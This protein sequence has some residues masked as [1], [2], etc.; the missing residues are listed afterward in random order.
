MCLMS[1]QN[2]VEHSHISPEISK[3]LQPL[4]PSFPV[5][6]SID[7][8]TILENDETLFI[9][10]LSTLLI[11]SPLG[12]EDLTVTYCFIQLLK[13]AYFQLDSLGALDKVLADCIISPYMHWRFHFATPAYSRQF[14]DFAKFMKLGMPRMHERRLIVEHFERSS[15]E[16]EECDRAMISDATSAMGG[17]LWTGPA[18]EIVLITCHELLRS[19]AK[20]EPLTEDAADRESKHR[21]RRTRSKEEKDFSKNK[22]RKATPAVRCS[23]DEQAGII[24]TRNVARSS[25]CANNDRRRAQVSRSKFEWHET[26]ATNMFG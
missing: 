1:C 23:N 7:F 18:E 25:L 14:A 21:M 20:H 12:L 4:L 11:S 6:R 5:L 24:G 8:W 22:R 26:L 17:G 16:D 15:M 2:E 3:P 13:D 10:A 19:R 9:D